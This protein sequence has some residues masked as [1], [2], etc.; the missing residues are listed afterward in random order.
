RRLAGVYALDLP[1]FD[2]TP[3]LVSP[4]TGGGMRGWRACAP[5]WVVS[6]PSTL[7]APFVMLVFQRMNTRYGAAFAA[8]SEP[9]VACVSHARGV[10]HFLVDADRMLDA[11]DRHLGAATLTSFKL[12][13]PDVRQNAQSLR[14]VAARVHRNDRNA[15]RDRLLNRRAERVGVRYG[16]DEPIRIG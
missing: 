3:M 7:S 9:D 13:L 4:S 12:G 6:S 2:T 10:A 1:L 8:S 16:D 5:L 11:G 15:S 14:H